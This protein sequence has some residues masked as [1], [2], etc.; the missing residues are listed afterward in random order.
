M[1]KK[2]SI[3]FDEEK[4]FIM[5]KWRSLEIPQI[6]PAFESIFKCKIFKVRDEENYLHI[7]AIISE[8]IA[9]DAIQ[10]LHTF[11]LHNSCDVED[12]IVRITGNGLKRNESIQKIVES[13]DFY[14]SCNF[15]MIHS[16]D[17]QIAGIR[18]LHKHNTPVFGCHKSQ[19]IVEMNKITHDSD[20]E[21]VGRLSFPLLL[22]NAR[23]GCTFYLL[24]NAESE[25]KRICAS[26]FGEATLL[27]MQNMLI[28]KKSHI[29]STQLKKMIR[30]GNSL[31][32]DLLVGDIY[33]SDSTSLGL[34]T[35]IIAASMGKQQIDMNKC[36]KE[37]LTK[38][39]YLMFCV[40]LG[41]LTALVARSEEVKGV[42]VTLGLYDDHDAHS[43]LASLID[44]YMH[45]SSQLESVC[46]SK[47][48]D[49]FMELGSLLIDENNLSC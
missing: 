36:T 38:S 18:Y 20:L 5:F 17:S 19:N 9:A 2:L 47:Y 16:N 31:N 30:N 15:M 48:S 14:S 27:A 40:N 29:D 32:C 42:L 7:S 25:P 13:F 10:N 1:G 8:L 37:D 43:L 6:D 33:G 11:V 41:N 39:A 44:Y 3:S 34:N 4:V 45:G 28:G 22:V 26:L 46:F 12:G 24:E 49:V 23:S 21:S 35:D